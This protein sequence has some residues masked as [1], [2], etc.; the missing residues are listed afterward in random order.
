MEVLRAI[1]AYVELGQ[2]AVLVV[3]SGSANKPDITARNIAVRRRI[4][5]LALV[6]KQQTCK[7]VV[8]KRA[9]VV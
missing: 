3:V 2:I 6:V 7:S 1:V 9:V 4:I 8:T 5:R